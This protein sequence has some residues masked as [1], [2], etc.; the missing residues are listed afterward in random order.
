VHVAAWQSLAARSMRCRNWQADES[1][2]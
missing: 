2:L 1:I